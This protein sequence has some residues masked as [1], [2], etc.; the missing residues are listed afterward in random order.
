MKVSK[1]KVKAIIV[2][3]PHQKNHPW[4]DY[5]DFYTGSTKIM[6]ENGIYKLAEELLDWAR[7]DVEAFKLSQFRLHRG[8]P[9]DTWKEWVRK[10][11]RFKEANEE[12]KEMIGNRR[13]IGAMRHELNYG[14]VG[15]TMPFY[16]P[17]WKEETVR[18]AS[19]KEGSSGDGKVM[20]TVVTDAV[21]NSPLVP[22]RKKEEE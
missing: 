8:I 9:R 5:Q 10:Y 17:E 16:D 15:F 18:R 12:A 21:P 7:N 1:Q 20:I 2:E 4:F 19:L 3:Q 6:S 14:V 22:E 11:P 13:E